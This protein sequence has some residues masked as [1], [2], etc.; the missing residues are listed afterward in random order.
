MKWKWILPVLFTGALLADTIDEVVIPRKTTIFIT[1]GRTINSKTARPGDKFFAH[2]SVPV[3]MND[4]VIIPGGSYVLGKVVFSE[5][6]GRVKGKSRLQLNWD[7]V[8][9]PSGVTR[10]IVAVVA[11]AEGYNTD[12]IDEKGSVEGAGGQGGEVAKGTTKGGATGGV[13]GGLAT[14]SWKGAGVGA[15]IGG[16][17]GALLSL[18]QRGDDVIMVKGSSLTIQLEDDVRFVKPAPPPGEKL[19]KVKKGNN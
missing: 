2:V 7:T 11:G 5:R 14:G 3:T 13:I 9:L 1:M 17:A 16:G 6:A 18:F 15:A 8:I 19:L 12:K 10:K 4:Q